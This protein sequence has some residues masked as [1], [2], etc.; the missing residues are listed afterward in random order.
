VPL[1]RA[2]VLPVVAAV[3]RMASRAAD[4][5]PAP[6]EAPASPVLHT[7]RDEL[8]LDAGCFWRLWAVL[9][10]LRLHEALP[11][12]WTTAGRVRGAALL[13]PD[14]E[15]YASCAHADAPSA[16]QGVHFCRACVRDVRGPALATELDGPV[17]ASVFTRL[18]NCLRALHAAH[19]AYAPLLARVCHHLVEHA[20]SGD[21]ASLRVATAQWPALPALLQ[22]LWARDAAALAQ[23][24]AER[25]PG[26][27][28]GDRECA[29]QVR[30]LGMVCEGELDRGADE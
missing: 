24:G 15:D 16:L 12:E 1:L 14:P 3:V 2:N 9:L 21:E 30:L 8:T 18:G 11:M 29:R 27:A 19:A 5:A 17:A 22:A 25:G 6:A 26:V 13:Q 7:A 28:L 4:A 20:L 10:A 23:H